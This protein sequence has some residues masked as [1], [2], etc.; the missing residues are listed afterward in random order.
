VW[1]TN[2][3]TKLATLSLS[4]CLQHWKSAVTSPPLAGSLRIKVILG[5]QI[6]GIELDASPMES[7]F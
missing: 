7:M 4:F 5:I 2:N 6:Q 3:F 1:T